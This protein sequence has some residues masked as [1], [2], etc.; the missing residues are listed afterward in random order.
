MRSFRVSRMFGIGNN[1]GPAIN[2]AE[3]Q[4]LTELFSGLFYVAASRFNSPRQLSKRIE[5]HPVN[6]VNLWHGWWR[7]SLNLCATSVFSVS[8]GLVFISIGSPQRHRE[9]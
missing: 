5:P 7:P 6:L 8:L 1:K 3:P 2:N 9:H 4:K